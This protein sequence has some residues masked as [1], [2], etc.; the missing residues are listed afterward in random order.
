MNNG[1]IEADAQKVRIR[2]QLADED[3]VGG[4]VSENLWAEPLGD[5]TFRLLNSPLFASGIS[6]NDIVIAEQ[7]EDVFEFRKVSTQ[8]GHSTYRL[9]LKDGRRIE[10][11]DFQRRWEAISSLGAT[12]ENANGVF[13]A[14]DIAPGKSMEEI[15]ECFEDGER[16]GVWVF[17]EANYEHSLSDS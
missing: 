14:V 1:S 10:S 9:Y 2:F 17:E 15:Y 3:Q 12:Y 4:M 8:G 5:S 11:G 7:V 6:V 16:S 13:V